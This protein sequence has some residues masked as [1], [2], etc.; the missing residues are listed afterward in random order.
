M[1]EIKKYSIPLYEDGI[2]T[3]FTV[4]FEEGDDKWKTLMS[5]HNEIP[6]FIN[7]N[8]KKEKK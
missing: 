6:S 2:K 4:D 1:K 5:L 3:E 8:T 7:V